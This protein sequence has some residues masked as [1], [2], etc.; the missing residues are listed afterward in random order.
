M[1][2]QIAASEYQM[3]THAI[4]DSATTWIL[5]TYKEFLKGK[6]NKRRR[7][8]HAQI[9]APE[10]FTLFENVIPSIQPTHATSE[11]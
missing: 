1:A 9:I 8:K 2:E 4:G 3:N 5:K 11:M 6:Q 7:I 10:Y